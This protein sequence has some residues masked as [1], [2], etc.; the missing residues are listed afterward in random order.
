MNRDVLERE[1]AAEHAATLFLVVVSVGTL[2]AL[3][4]LVG[5]MIYA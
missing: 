1:H 2:M 3:F 4:A 5:Y